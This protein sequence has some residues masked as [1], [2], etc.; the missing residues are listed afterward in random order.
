MAVYQENYTTNPKFGFR[1]IKPASHA[2]ATTPI[3]A[4]GMDANAPPAIMGSAEPTT[5][6][7]DSTAPSREVSPE[8]RQNV[9]SSYGYT[10][11]TQN[12]NMMMG[13]LGTLAGI[14]GLSFLQGEDS[15]ST[16]GQPGTY[17]AQ[18]NVFG[19][20]GVAYDPI[21]G[22]VG[23]YK[24]IGTWWDNKK[25]GYD[26]LREAGLNPVAAGLGDYY[27][28]PYYISDM[29]RYYGVTPANKAGMLDTLGM[30]RSNTLG[31]DI[32]K[33]GSNISHPGREWEGY[34]ITP[35]MLGLDPNTIS[36]SGIKALLENPQAKF[37][38]KGTIGTTNAIP[39]SIVNTEFGPGVVNESGQIQTAAGTVV[40]MSGENQGNFIQPNTYGQTPYAN[41]L[42]D[43]E[44]VGSTTPSEP[45]IVT[46]PVVNTSND[47]E[48]ANSGSGTVIQS[49]NDS[50]GG[51][52]EVSNWWNKGGPVYA[53]PG[54]YIDPNRPDTGGK[55]G[56]MPRAPQA[57]SSIRSTMQQPVAQ[58]PQPIV[59]Q[60]PVQP[61]GGK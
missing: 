19:D 60:Q 28:S 6:N 58:Q 25:S 13:A 9:A 17:D 15:E 48:K 3:N 55:G 52:Y 51:S 34:N 44:L 11:G 37:A 18:G 1:Y 50:Y 24:D 16:F 35:E 7:I 38:D 45:P 20:D 30:V 57:P 43:E 47:E 5:N 33:H 4:V 31:E 56:G 46:A 32:Y 8:L 12:P 29:S 53:S 39:G 10:K 49:D 40:Q 23:N 41:A 2:P 61:A 42:D 27:N 36:S 14:P 54:K 59:Q 22:D 21:S 26:S